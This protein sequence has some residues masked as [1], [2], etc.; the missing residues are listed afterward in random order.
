MMRIPILFL[1]MLM[2]LAVSA[3][4]ADRLKTEI[5]NPDWLTCKTDAQCRATYLS[6]HGW[7][8]VASAHEADV[9]R[10]YV[11]ENNKALSVRD[12]AGAAD[13]PQPAAVCRANAC[14]VDTTTLR[15]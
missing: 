13:V 12:C 7:V 14:A 11:I 3:G 2:V 4:C 1:P 5:E 6:C 8:A 15:P 9:Q 10:W